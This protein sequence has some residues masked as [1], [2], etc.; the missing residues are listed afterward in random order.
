MCELNDSMK[1]WAFR[2]IMREWEAYMTREVDII[3]EWGNDSNKY[4]M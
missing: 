2:V 3:M 1:I 4:T